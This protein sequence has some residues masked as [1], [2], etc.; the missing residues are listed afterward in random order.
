MWIL[1]LLH[2]EMMEIQQMEMA[3]VVLALKRLAIVD[4]EELQQQS[5]FEIKYEE[6]EYKLPLK[7]VMIKTQLIMMDAATVALLN[8]DI[9][10]MEDL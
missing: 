10:V 4:L 8:L 9:L 5:L 7:N 6:M 2:T 1:S 3:E